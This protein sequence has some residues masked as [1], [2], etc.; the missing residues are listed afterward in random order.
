MFQMVECIATREWPGWKECVQSWD[1]TASELHPKNIVANTDVISAY[2][3]CYER[4]NEPILAFIHDDVM[5][6]EKG[7]DAR[8]LRQFTDPRVGMVGFGGALGHGR[9]ELY[10]VPY[11]LPDLARQNFMSNLRHAEIHGA[12]F[13]GERD[14][15]ILDGFALF[16][17][18]E[19][20][21]KI[22]GW[23]PKWTYFMYS[24]GLCCEARRQGYRIR[25][26]GVDCDHLGGKSSGYI[27]ATDNYEEA[28]RYFYENNRDV[29][30][31]RV[32]DEYGRAVLD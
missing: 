3:I 15:A 19:I 20:L 21:A 14:V 25:L 5:I 31:Y 16:V 24:E 6:Y 4:T 26:A 10:R 13:T 9:P 30:P 8:V 1:D 32:G 23:N 29:M 7:W 11:H 18:R 22:G 27:P 2:Q 28:H 12:R 17:R